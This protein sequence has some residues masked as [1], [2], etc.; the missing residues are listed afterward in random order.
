MH[1]PWSSQARAGGVMASERI[2]RSTYVL[3][4]WNPSPTGTH[5]TLPLDA[6]LLDDAA[7]EA[8]NTA[9]WS[10]VINGAGISDIAMRAA[11]AAYAA[12]VAVVP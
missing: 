8:A 7:L 4:A 12:H 3:G 6:A 9:H 10:A 2:E 11:L 1:S 5:I